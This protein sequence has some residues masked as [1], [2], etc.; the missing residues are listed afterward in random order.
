MTESRIGQNVKN[1]MNFY[2]VK[3]IKKLLTPI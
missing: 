3:N 2:T 1:D